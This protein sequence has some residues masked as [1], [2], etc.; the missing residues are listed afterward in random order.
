[1]GCPLLRAARVLLGQGEGTGEGTGQGTGEGAGGGDR[2]GDWGGYREGTG[3]GTGEGAGAGS[4]PQT[5]PPR[6]PVPDP[7]LLPFLH[8]LPEVSRADPFRSLRAQEVS[9]TPRLPWAP[10]RGKYLFPMC[11]FGRLS[12]QVRERVPLREA[13]QPGEGTCAASGG[14]ATR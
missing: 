3:V 6:G 14:S 10:V 4:G 11:R 2:G 7:E 9:T 12:N 1:V 13:Q 5:S 8:H